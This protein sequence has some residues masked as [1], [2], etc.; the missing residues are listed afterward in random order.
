MSTIGK[1]KW[2]DTTKG[3]GFIESDGSSRDVF[4]HYSALSGPG[5]RALTE[6]QQVSFEIVP[7]IKGPQADKV[8]VIQ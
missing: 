1:V 3:Y 8:S 5:Y 7:G 6:G 4:V 2:F